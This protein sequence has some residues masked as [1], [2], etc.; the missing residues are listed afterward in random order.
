MGNDVV[1]ALLTQWTQF[2]AENDARLAELAKRGEASAET[3]AKVDRLN[4]MVADSQARVDAMEVRLNR[5]G[6]APAN[7]PAQ[8]EHVKGFKAWMSRGILNAAMQ[9][10]TTTEGGH[11]VPTPM[12][13]EILQGLQDISIMRRVGARVI[14]MTAWKMDV[15]TLTNS[16][17][18]ILTA[19]EGSVSEVEPTVGTVQAVAYRYTKLAKVSKELVA[20]SAFD[21]WGTILAPDY[22]Q[23]FAKAENAAFTTGDGSGKPQ[24]I[25]VG[26]TAGVTAVSDTTPTA[27]E[28]IDLFYALDERHQAEATWMM[29]NA[30]AKIIRKLKD[31]DGQ[32]LWTPG[33]AA[34]PQSILGRPLVI[35]SSMP[36]STTGLKAYIV[37]NFAYYWIFDRQEMALQ[38]LVELYAGNGQ[39]GFLADKRFDGHV[40]LA[41]AFQYMTM[42]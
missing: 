40:M 30:S 20:D 33:F 37:G 23:A 24:G 41:T 17:A 12:Y 31:G 14:P 35:N 34:A 10:G 18:A 13:S 2:R 1:D 11:T 32:Y 22:A 25:T 27:D 8:D 26:G 15:P 21:I 3:N 42:A 38:R 16:T 19:E 5:P 9:E 39:V 6:S 29:A 28:I 36:A 7:A 4:D